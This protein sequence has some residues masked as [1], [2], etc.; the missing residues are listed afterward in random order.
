[1]VLF[2]DPFVLILTA[3]VSHSSANV[4]EE[5]YGEVLESR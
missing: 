3:F 4:W 2:N 5:N 1:M